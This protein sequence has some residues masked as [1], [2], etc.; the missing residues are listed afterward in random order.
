MAI[1]VC[2]CRKKQGAYGKVK[3]HKESKLSQMLHLDEI[4]SAITLLYI[5][6][7]ESNLESPL[8]Q[9]TFN[10]LDLKFCDDILCKVSRSFAAVIRQLPSLLTVIERVDRAAAIPALTVGVMFGACLAAS[11]SADPQA[12]DDE[13]GE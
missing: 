1:C 6:P 9:E 4:W 7:L 5:S 11:V 8:I 10:P 3:T 13:S 12:G 2:A